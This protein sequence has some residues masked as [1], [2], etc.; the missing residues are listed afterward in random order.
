M[1]KEKMTPAARKEVCRLGRLAIEAMFA[2][3]QANYLLTKKLRQTVPMDDVLSLRLKAAQLKAIV[4]NGI[5][6][7][8]QEGLI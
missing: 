3:D 7:L 6:K 5:Q 2:D 8:R 1:F 4:F